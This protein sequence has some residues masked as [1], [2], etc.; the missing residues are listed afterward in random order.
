M[1]GGIRKDVKPSLIT[2]DSIKSL[3]SV[4][5]RPSKALSFETHIIHIEVKELVC[6]SCNER[7]LIYHGEKESD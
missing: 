1:K 3:H 7:P 6:A 4:T 2:T 5:P